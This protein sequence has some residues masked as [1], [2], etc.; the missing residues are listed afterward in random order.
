MEKANDSVHPFFSVIVPVYNGEKFLKRCISSITKQTFSDFELILVDDG[1]KD[2]SSAIC[3]EY[4]TADQRIRYIYKENRGSFHTRIKGIEQARGKYVLFC[5]VDDRYTSKNVFYTLSNMLKDS[6]YDVLQFGHYRK[7]GFFKKQSGPKCKAEVLN[8]DVFLDQH[9]PALLCNTWEK[10]DLTGFGTDKVY[11]RELLL[12]MLE[13]MECERI[14]WGD[15]TITNLYTLCECKSIAFIP[16]P[17]YVYY[18]S[19][20][21]TKRFSERTMY[22]L[23]NVKQAQ[24]YFLGKLDHKEYKYIRNSQFSEVASW[25]YLYLQDGMQEIGEERLRKLIEDILCLKSFQNA[26]NYYIHESKENWTAVE[27]L[28][29]GDPDEYIRAVKNCPKP[30]SG[31]KQL[32][33]RVIK[34]II[35]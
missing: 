12:P 23:D 5:D 13:L 21:G 31:S 4:A 19:T 9:Y 34:K 2:N 30:A 27:L 7:R 3:Q 24:T 11:R 29:K 28:R 10:S 32:I 14:F 16:D 8:K 26:R 22:D 20:G 25:F 18:I 17:L 6:P 1:S 33:K 15:D 35:K